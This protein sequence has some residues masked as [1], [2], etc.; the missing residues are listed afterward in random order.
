MAELR[1][2]IDSDW[3]YKECSAMCFIETWLEEDTPDA[4]VAPWGSL[5]TVPTGQP[6]L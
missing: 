2:L 6:T 4:A 5:P 3:N 1:L